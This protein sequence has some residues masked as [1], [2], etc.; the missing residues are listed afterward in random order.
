[1]LHVL[2]DKRQRFV[3]MFLRPFQDDF[4]MNLTKLRA[5][6]SNGKGREVKLI[7]FVCVCAGPLSSFLPLLLSLLSTL[8]CINNL[9]PISANFLFVWI[10]IIAFITTSAALP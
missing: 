9:Y 6:R 2:D 5:G 7:N 8:T 3:C 1:M 10:F 4:V